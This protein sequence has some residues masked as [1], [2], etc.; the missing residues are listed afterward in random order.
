MSVTTTYKVLGQLAPTD[1]NN[2]NL[3]TVPASTESII[4]TLVIA[5][6]TSSAATCR[7]FVRVDAAAAA[8]SNAILYDVNIGANSIATFTLGITMDAT[9]VITVQSGTADALTFHA[10]GSELA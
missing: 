4:S 8:A 1:T 3:Y 5:N 9:D 7:V 10:F 2:A 6:T